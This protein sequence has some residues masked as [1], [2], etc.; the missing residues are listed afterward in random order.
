MVNFNK[1]NTYTF[2][3]ET[4]KGSKST[5][6]TI[7][8]FKSITRARRALTDLLKQYKSKDNVFCIATIRNKDEILISHIF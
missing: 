1:Y 4:I 2:V 5:K 7:G 6:H 8:T 3:L